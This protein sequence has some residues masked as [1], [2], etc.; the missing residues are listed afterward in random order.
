MFYLFRHLYTAAAMEARHETMINMYSV[1]WPWGGEF[2]TVSTLRLAEHAKGVSSD[3]SGQCWTP[4]Q[5][6][7]VGTQMTPIA[8]LNTESGNPWQHEDSSEPS[9][10]CAL[11]SHCQFR[12]R[13]D[14]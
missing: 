9:G 10:H 5:T 2:C 4:S 13:K 14:E 11:P 6:A 7:A 1:R 3:P 12:S 8:H